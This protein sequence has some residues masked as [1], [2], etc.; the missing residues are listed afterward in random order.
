MFPILLS[1]WIRKQTAFKIIT[2][3]VTSGKR[4]SSTSHA[5][6]ALLLA[7][8]PVEAWKFAGNNNKGL[9]PVN[10]PNYPVIVWCGESV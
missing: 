2:G 1:V 3:G 4:V 9:S 8:K 6:A 7:P 10:V 5:L